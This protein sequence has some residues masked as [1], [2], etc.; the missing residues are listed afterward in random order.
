[1]QKKYLD[2]VMYLVIAAIGAITIQQTSTLPEAMAPDVG[3]AYLPVSLAWI[4]IIFCVIGLVQTIIKGG[5]VAV[6]FSGLKKIFVTIA[7]LA[8]FF[9]LWEYLGY[10]YLLSTVFLAGLLIY[11]AS[12]EALTGRLILACIVGSLIFN[13]LLYCFFTFVLYTKF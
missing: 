9:V 11:Y 5:Q 3:P 2:I 7:A 1:M 12:D 4:M 13:V 6:E 10:F 8:V